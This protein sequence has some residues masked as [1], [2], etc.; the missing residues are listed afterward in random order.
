MAFSFL[1]LLLTF[2]FKNIYMVQ[3]NDK[4][5]CCEVYVNRE[6]KNSL[7]SYI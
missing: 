1:S 3:G 6:A 7:V 2:N 4:G 5:N